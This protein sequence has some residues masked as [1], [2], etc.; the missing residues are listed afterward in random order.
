M[1]KNNT[2]FD[3][4]FAAIASI[5]PTEKKYELAKILKSLRI[6]KYETLC[7]MFSKDS[8][9]KNHL[10][11][12]FSKSDSQITSEDHQFILKL[13]FSSDFSEGE[14]LKNPYLSLSNKNFSIFLEEI[15]KILSIRIFF[16]DPF[17]NLLFGSTSYKEIVI[18]LL[19]AEK[20]LYFPRKNCDEKFLKD[21][22]KT[23]KNRR[24]C[25]ICYKILTNDDLLLY[26]DS[27][28]HVE[29]GSCHRD[30]GEKKGGFCELCSEIW[31]SEEIRLYPCFNC[32]I[33][34][35]KDAM[36]NCEICQR[37]SC[38]MCFFAKGDVT[39]GIICPKCQIFK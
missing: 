36:L 10:L 26:F 9:P 15:T 38:K 32:R 33:G 12:L 23:D 39:S 11:S 1:K 22:T 18:I 19:D 2:G 24:I 6:Q 25:S 17:K 21:F 8:L 37:Y 31:E 7:A 16:S 29:C 5:F 34:T 30:F 13:W 3:D 35:R 4:V 14:Y 27:C 28:G 20:K